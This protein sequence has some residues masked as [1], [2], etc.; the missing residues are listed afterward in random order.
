M[1]GGVLAGAVDG[2]TTAANPLEMAPLAA[3]TIAAR[4]V[5]RHAVV[6]ATKLRAHV[7]ADLIESALLA[8]VGVANVDDAEPACVSVLGGNSIT[9][10][11]GSCTAAAGA[12]VTE[13]AAPDDHASKGIGDADQFVMPRCSSWTS[14][15]P[16]CTRAPHRLQTIKVIG[17]RARARRLSQPHPW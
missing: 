14:F 16:P 12:I 1:F 15:G 5:V 3:A 10:T 9:V 17:I 7:D 13:G 4:A 8:V 2:E 11:P 6:R